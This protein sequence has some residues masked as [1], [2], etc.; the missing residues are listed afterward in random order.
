MLAALDQENRLHSQLNATNSKPLE[1]PVKSLNP[2]TPARTNAHP[3]TPFKIPLNDTRAA[4]SVLKPA[5][6]L[7]DANAARRN[8]LVTPSVTG[9]RAPLG[10]KTTNAKTKVFQSPA[11]PNVTDDAPKGNEP[12]ARKTFS[13]RRARPRVSHAQTQ[14]VEFGQDGNV[15]EERDI[16]YMPPRPA[17]LP[18][19]PEDFPP[20]MDYSM[21]KG[22]N[23]TLG[24]F[25]TYSDNFDE[26]GN[27]LF[28]RRYQE[29]T[30]RAHRELDAQEQKIF[31]EISLSNYD[32]PDYPEQSRNVNISQGDRMLEGRKPNDKPLT[33][34]KVPIGQEKKPGTVKS[35][36]AAA[37]LSKTPNVQT[38][39]A[40]KTKVPGKTSKLPTSLLS[41]PKREVK[42]S[43]PS[44]MRHTAAAAS[45]KSTIGYSKGRAT[46][47]TLKAVAPGFS[48]RNEKN[49]SATTTKPV[50]RPASPYSAAD[51]ATFADFPAVGGSAALFA[52]D[53]QQIS[54]DFAGLDLGD[55]LA[56][57]AEAEEDFK[58]VW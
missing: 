36:T 33:G 7:A 3:K 45:S 38:K 50:T 53:D 32:T 13:A 42:P 44:P 23:L 9:N 6:K 4:K 17:D 41:R 26:D 24:V 37:L 58:L 29:A 18:D 22:E 16:E 56:G 19:Y 51:L 40:P 34:R 15:L 52:Q 2:K 1:Q 8:A 27:S 43:N 10:Q 25:S 57:N 11:L 48:R 39:P 46:S 20:N 21:L 47:N 28:D 35:K 31:D 54:S 49:D 55:L 14:K 12:S 5:A 30:E